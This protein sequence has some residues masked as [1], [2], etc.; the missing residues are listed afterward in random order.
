[1]GRTLQPL[2]GTAQVT[3]D[4]GIK[5]HRTPLIFLHRYVNLIYA[6]QREANMSQKI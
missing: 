2:R 1:M 3:L 4:M 6:T 5:A